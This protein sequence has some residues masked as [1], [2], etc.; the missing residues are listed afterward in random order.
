M[1]LAAKLS[2]SAAICEHTDEPSIT[3]TI[4]LDKAGQILRSAGTSTTWRKHSIRVMPRLAAASRWPA[5]TP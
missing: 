1:K 5:G 2:S 3:M 4:W